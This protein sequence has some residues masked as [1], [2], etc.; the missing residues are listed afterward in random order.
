MKPLP[1][2]SVP[3]SADSLCCLFL[4]EGHGSTPTGSCGSAQQ[5]D[6][7]ACQAARS[8]PRSPW[9]QRGPTWPGWCR[10]AGFAKAHWDLGYFTSVL[11]AA[12][13]ELWLSAGS[14]VPQMPLAV[15]PQR[16]SQQLLSSH[17]PVRP[18]HAFFVLFF[19]ASH[20][21]P[22]SCLLLTLCLA[23]QLAD[24]PIQTP[25]LRPNIH[26]PSFQAR[27]LLVRHV[28]ATSQDE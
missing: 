23:S 18:C 11:P 14:L 13:A 7:Q 26:Q 3:L 4:S 16:T 8:I 28:R 5:Q 19:T 2:G 12:G 21:L 15:R 6:K 22:V 17:V 24:P 25:C 9:G 20:S 27:R 10:Q 1:R